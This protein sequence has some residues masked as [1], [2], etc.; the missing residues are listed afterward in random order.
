MTDGGATERDGTMQE[1]GTGGPPTLEIA[2]F[3]ATL[4]L[5]RPRQHNRIEPG[6]LPVLQDLLDRA[7]Q[8]AG[9]R[10]LLLASEGRSFSAGYHLGAVAGAE[11]TAKD[12][13]PG[14]KADA[15][16]GQSAFES[17]CQR[18]EAVRLPTLCALQGSVYGGATDLALACDFRLGVHDMQMVMPAVRLGLHYYP[19]G[20][21]RYVTRLG[22]G[23]AKRLFLTGQPIGAEEMLRI[24]F[25]DELVAPADL[26]VR[27]EY[28]VE[29]LAAQAPLAVMGMKRALNEIARA[30]PDLPAMRAAIAATLGSDDLREGLK[31]IAERRPPKFEGR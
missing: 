3:R 14:G 13:E 9:V 28:W 8:A 26:A 20:L 25:L 21:T 5:N 2:G 19:S 10:V 15:A 30:Q 23:P 24:G 16:S 7:E 1:A 11:R 12:G 27:V 22:L 6:D 4:H 31:A 18:L 29:M 17:L